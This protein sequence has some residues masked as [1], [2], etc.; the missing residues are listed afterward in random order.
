MV[1]DMLLFWCSWFK[2]R[3]IKLDLVTVEKLSFHFCRVLV[4]AVDCV[5]MNLS[6]RLTLKSALRDTQK[7]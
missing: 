6:A 4:S 3:F 1:T 5:S 2:Y 7:V